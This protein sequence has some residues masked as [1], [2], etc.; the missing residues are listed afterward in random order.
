MVT[1]IDVSEN[2]W[3]VKVRANPSFLD[4]RSSTRKAERTVS[5]FFIYCASHVSR[6]FL[7]MIL[8]QGVGVEREDI[9]F[10][11]RQALDR[12]FDEKRT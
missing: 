6:F 5:I 7:S 4:A 3:E 10:T 8:V 11:S 2:Y 1:T 9:P 12:F